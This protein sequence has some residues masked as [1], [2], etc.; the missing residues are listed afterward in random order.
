MIDDR[1]V[2]AA[3]LRAEGHSQAASGEA[4]GVSAR[5]IR[6]WEREGKL[7]AALQ[8]NGSTPETPEAEVGLS[9]ARRR[10]EL[11]LAKKHEMDLRKKEGDLLDRAIVRDHLERVGQAARSAPKRL[12][13]EAA[14]L[15]GCE[16]R[17]AMQLLELLVRPVLDA[18]REP[19]TRES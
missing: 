8:I 16:P 7:E 13:D 14:H 1:H 3:K 10:R 12:A 18:L 4:V 15:I 11:A 9:E 19:F 2:T 5:T 6:T 17:E